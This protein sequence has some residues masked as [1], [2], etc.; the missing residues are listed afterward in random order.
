MINR[1]FIDRHEY[2]DP[3]I[4]A[5]GQWPLLHSNHSRQ[6]RMITLDFGHEGG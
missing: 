4:L 5:P 1:S 6:K 3:F 2:E